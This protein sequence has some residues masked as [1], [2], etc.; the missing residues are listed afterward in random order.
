RQLLASRLRGWTRQSAASPDRSLRF[1]LSVTRGAGDSVSVSVE[2]RLSSR[3]LEDEPRTLHQLRLLQRETQRRA[4]TLARG[5]AEA[6]DAYLSSVA[7]WDAF[8][9]ESAGWISNRTLKRLL[10]AAAGTPTLV[11]DGALDPE[12]AARC[13][14]TP[15]GVVRMAARAAIIVPMCETRGQGLVLDLEVRWPDGRTRPLREVL[16]LR[17]PVTGAVRHPSFL[18]GD[19]EI[20]VA[21][22]LPPAEILDPFATA[23]ALPLDPV[24]HAEL[25][26]RMAQ[27][28]PSIRESLL[29]FARVRPV[30]PTVAI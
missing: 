8:P 14:L 9:R 3:R 16:L 28:F 12:L 19:G 13:G 21:A 29:P 11:W 24:D 25:L 2:P 26:E 20:H 6:L 15:G 23:G 7:D 1:V 22:E 18:V 27:R 4:G 10:D 30:L 17:G 5:Q